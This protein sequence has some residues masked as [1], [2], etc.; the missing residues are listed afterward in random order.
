MH[1]LYLSAQ[2]LLRLGKDGAL[3][4]VDPASMRGDVAVVA[5]FIETTITRVTVPQAKGLDARRVLER[6]VA[7][8]FRDTDYR[9]GVRLG[10]SD[11][12][13]H[14][15][16]LAI[17][18]GAQKTLDAALA[19]G[20]EHGLRVRAVWI[21]AM[22]V[23]ELVRRAKG[24]PDHVLVLLATP[25]GVRQVIVSRG[26]VLLGRLIPGDAES[27]TVEHLMTEVDRT[28]QFVRNSR[29]LPREETL[30]VLCWGLTQ[31]RDA[32]AAALPR[33][34]EVV[35]MPAIRGIAPPETGGLPAVMA[36][37][38]RVAPK[39]QLA[40]LR[41]RIHH[42]GRRWRQGMYATTAAGLLVIG[43][44]WMPLKSETRELNE[45]ANATRRHAAQVQAPLD[46][47]QAKIAERNIPLAV[48][49]TAL[50]LHTTRLASTERFAREAEELS[51][52]LTE[53]QGVEIIALKWREEPPTSAQA[54]SC[55]DPA[56]VVTLEAHLAADV[57]QAEREV[58]LK[59]FEETLGSGPYWTVLPSQAI[60]NTQ[61]LS[62]EG[63]EAQLSAPVAYCLG[64]K[65]R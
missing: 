39:L 38:T 27:F 19:T 40:P 62:S 47:L 2:Q 52:V 22:L 21:P 8:E 49:A 5:D 46:A 55:K 42:L 28:V 59:M 57:P 6:R 29:L 16:V 37:A 1:V 25:S 36:A 56:T 48:A 23:A 24:L 18:I 13:G 58:R 30:G 9:L 54:S 53:A 41:V 26:K 7:Q 51:A 11:K 14:D 32:I 34:M 31:P 20:L 44:M 10:K 15:E 50:G 35:G 65:P 17:G 12:A 3:H 4:P 43:A 61:T 45:Q 63:L 33:G 64:R 60:N